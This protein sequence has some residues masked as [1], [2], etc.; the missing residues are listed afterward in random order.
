MTL[1]Q[2]MQACEEY[3]L[4]SDFRERPQVLESLLADDFV[5]VAASGVIA[6]RA[7]VLQWLLDKDQR[8]RW[9][10]TELQAF[11]LG[12]GLRHVR[13]H[14]RQLLPAPSPGNGS[15]HSSLWRYN[16]SLQ[17]WQLYYHQATRL[18]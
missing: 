18:P 15:L 17:C 12:A 16:D 5:E 11:E 4:H 14:A 8:A 9:Q 10:L 13:Y 2:Q 7:A 3:L 6:S 1:A